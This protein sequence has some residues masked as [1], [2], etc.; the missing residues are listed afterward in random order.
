MSIDKPVFRFI[1]NYLFSNYKGKKLKILDFGCGKGELVRLLYDAGFDVYGSDSSLFY[2]DFYSITDKQLFDNGRIKLNDENGRSSFP[3]NYFD[4]II[5][6]MVLEHVENLEEVIDE[7]NNKM[8][9]D[10]A[11]LHFAPVQESIR[12]GHIKQYFIHWLPKNRIRY[13]ICLC[14]RLIGIGASYKKNEPVHKYIQKR[15]NAIDNHCFYRSFD[16]FCTIFSRRNNIESIE[17]K[18]LIFRCKEKSYFFYPVIEK[19]F[20]FQIK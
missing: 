10:G 9:V 19:N 3:D 20:K 13:L 2:K 4:I 1:L 12:E 18:Y 16:E 11:M 8:K 15:L 17:Y 6:N 5:T 7:L 14:Q